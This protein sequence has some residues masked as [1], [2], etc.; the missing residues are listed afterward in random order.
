MLKTVLPVRLQTKVP[1]G[2]I[3]AFTSTVAILDV[4]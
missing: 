3:L 2:G 1:S 4:T